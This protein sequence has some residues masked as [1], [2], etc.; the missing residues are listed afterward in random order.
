MREASYLCSIMFRFTR[1]LVLL[2]GLMVFISTM[3]GC[4]PKSGYN[5]YLHM[6]EKPSVKQSRDDKKIIK[7]G[8]K[9][10]KKQME[11]NRKHL[12]GR[13]HGPGE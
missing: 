7:K 2:T 12:F 1:P 5:P 10:Y 9:T 6:K 11:S 4:K 13:K 3:D 8:N